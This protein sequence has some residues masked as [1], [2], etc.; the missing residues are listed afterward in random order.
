MEKLKEREFPGFESPMLAT[1]TDT[2]FDDAGWIY[3][4]KLDGVRCVVTICEGEVKLYSRNGNAISSTY[5]ELVDA[6]RES[7]AQDV[8][9][10]GE[11]VAFDGKV[12]SFSKLQ[13]RMQLQD[14]EKIR[15]TTVRV[16]LYLFD[17]L[18]IDGNDTT[19]LPLKTRKKLLKSTFNWN[20]RLRFTPHRNKTGKAYLA[21]ACEKGWEGLIAKDASAKYVHSRSRNWLK[22]K[23]SKGQELVIGGFSEPEGERRGFGA[24][25]VGYYKNGGLQYAG[26]V[27]TGFDDEFLEKWRKKFDAVEIK[28]S[29]FENFDADKQGKNHWLKPRYVGQFGF[30][31]WTS[32]GKLRHPRF[33]GMRTDKKPEDVVKEEPK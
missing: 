3:E 26:K 29:P 4:R 6:L 33:L 30:T 1:L 31:E 24:L 20:K 15:N 2:Y 7:A 9:A 12:T 32:A 22:F 13:N 21:E 27:G 25:L 18:Y 5:P 28:K 19:S 16:W 23:C 8:V 11:I 17:I 10:D 14:P